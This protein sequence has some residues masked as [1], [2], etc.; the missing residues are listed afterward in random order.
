MRAS[1]KGMP[2]PRPILEPVPKPDG[3][4]VEDTLVV[5]GETALGAAVGIEVGEGEGVAVL[6]SEL[7]V[8]V[9][10]EVATISIVVNAF[11]SPV[12]VVVFTLVLQSQPTWLLA[13]H[14]IRCILRTQVYDIPAS[15]IVWVWLVTLRGK[16]VKSCGLCR[17]KSLDR[18]WIPK[19]NL[20]MSDVL[21]L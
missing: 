18:Q 5:V 8:E 2:M 3:A 15:I 12:N 9:Y 7:E 1:P 16:N 13:Q 10:V 6:E 17:Y 19:K 20:Y 11:K 14:Q 4:E 21:L